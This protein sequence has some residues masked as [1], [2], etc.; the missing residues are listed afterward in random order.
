MYFDTDFSY[1]FLAS[2]IHTSEINRAVS[3]LKFIVDTMVGVCYCYFNCCAFMWIHSCNFNKWGA[4]FKISKDYS[5]RTCGKEELDSETTTTNVVSWFSCLVC[6]Q[7]FG[8]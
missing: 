8:L 7:D 6:F 3:M 2:L 5:S 4:F 1:A